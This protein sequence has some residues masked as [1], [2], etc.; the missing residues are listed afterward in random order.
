MFQNV[1]DSLGLLANLIQMHGQKGHLILNLV[2][3]ILKPTALH[4]KLILGEGN[5]HI[6]GL[7]LGPATNI[8]PLHEGRDF[9]L[10]E[11]HRVWRKSFKHL[12]GLDRSF[13][14]PLVA[15]IDTCFRQINN[16]FLDEPND[17]AEDFQLSFLES[18]FRQLDT[19]LEKK[20]HE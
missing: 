5:T 2:F 19:G 4:K 6:K 15:H 12:Y 3:Y 8:D 16:V 17:L 14:T 18:G 9:C 20:L 7:G 10:Q 11:L 13:L 1:F